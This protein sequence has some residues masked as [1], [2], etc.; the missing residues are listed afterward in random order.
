[1]P[2]FWNIWSRKKH[3]SQVSQVTQKW[4]TQWQGHIWCLGQWNTLIFK[5]IPSLGFWWTWAGD[6][7]ILLAIAIA[8]F[9]YLA[10]G[11]LIA[12]RVALSAFFHNVHGS[13]LCSVPKCAWCSHEGNPIDNEN[14]SLLKWGVSS[15]CLTIIFCFIAPA[16]SAT[17][18]ALCWD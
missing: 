18:V 2:G 6:K 15:K 8:F 14:W 3:W 9:I 13:A 5:T 7:R 12:C 4:L 11:L 1:M 10:F 16:V 17:V